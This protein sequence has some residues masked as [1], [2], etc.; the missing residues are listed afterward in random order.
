M[1]ASSK[2]LYGSCEDFLVMFDL[3]S[4]QDMSYGFQWSRNSTTM[5]EFG[6]RFKGA[7]AGIP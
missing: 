2:L 1:F 6:L 7:W 5:P 3:L 4:A